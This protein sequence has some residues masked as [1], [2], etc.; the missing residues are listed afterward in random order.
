MVHDMAERGYPDYR[1]ADA[2]AVRLLLRGPAPVGRLGAVL[3]VSRQAARKVARGLEQRSL[4]ITETDPDDA[5]KVNVRL[6]EAGFAYGRAVT[7]V[8]ASL[9]RELAG[10]I[11]PAALVATDHVLR[12]AI[13]DR[14]L[15]RAAARIPPPSL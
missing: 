15:A 2:A 12:A 10:R 3:D 9:N 14:R 11:E 4:A 1:I 13:D 6:T 5:R 7:D 8:I